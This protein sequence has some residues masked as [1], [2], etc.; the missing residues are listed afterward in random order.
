MEEVSREESGEAI[1]ESGG[2]NGQQH[3]GRFDQAEEEVGKKKISS[4]IGFRALSY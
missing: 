4:G 1:S 3:N 2:D